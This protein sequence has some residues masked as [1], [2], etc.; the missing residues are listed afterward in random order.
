MKKDI[1]ISIMVPALNEE[2]TLKAAVLDLQNVLLEKVE[3]LE[4][5]IVNDGSNDSTYEIARNL[6]ESFPYIKVINHKSN[7]GIG[8][9]YKDALKVARGLYFTWFPAD[10]E[11]SAETFLSF[12]PYLS[13]DTVI[14]CHHLG[15]DP[16]S[17]FRKALS[18]IYTF[19][20]NSYFGVHVSYYN[21][22]TVL[23]TKVARSFP[24]VSRGFSWSAENLLRAMKKG[25]RL[26]EI[27]L[28]LNSRNYGKSKALTVFSL[29]RMTKDLFRLF[30]IRD[31]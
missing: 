16:R 21:G 24:L 1:S 30:R 25:C 12:L 26:K 13:E 8:V 10:C 11:D 7:S 31:L 20:I 17:F 4:I 2:R 3:F 23:P 29:S 6:S 9:C 15:S 19:T 22:I 5:I 18:K 28:P 27:Y 14:S